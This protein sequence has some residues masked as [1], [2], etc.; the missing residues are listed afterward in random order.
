MEIPL[1]N[2]DYILKRMPQKGGW[3]YVELPDIPLNREAAFGMLKV[4][5]SID[6]YE[7][8]G[9]T[10][11]P[12]G[13][14]VMMMSVNAEMRKKIKKEEGDTVHITLYADDRPYELPALLVT[15]L[16]DAG[17]YELFLKMKKSEQ[18]LCAKRI[19][20]SPREATVEERILKI[21]DHLKRVESYL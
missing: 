8:S 4:R 17:V 13:K 9:H 12:F 18:R 14:G 16:Q 10:L 1:V 6:G 15:K 20:S 2:K 21:I 7:I 11:M 5:G 19:F 3:T